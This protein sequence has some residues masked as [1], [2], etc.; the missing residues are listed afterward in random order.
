M[1]Q[2][3]RQKFNHSP[4]DNSIDILHDDE[5]IY[6][7]YYLNNICIYISFVYY[8]CNEVVVSLKG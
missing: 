8:F 6:Y 3:P 4:N 2:L 1:L 5:Q 7:N